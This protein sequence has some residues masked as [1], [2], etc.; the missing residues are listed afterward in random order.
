MFPFSINGSTYAVFLFV[1]VSCYCLGLPPHSNH[2]DRDCQPHKESPQR[3][4][5]INF[6][7]TSLIT[8]QQTLKHKQLR[9][10]EPAGEWARTTP[11]N[12]TVQSSRNFQTLQRITTLPFACFPPCLAT[13]NV[14]CSWWFH[15][16]CFPTHTT[17]HHKKSGYGYFYYSTIDGGSW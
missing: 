11:P 12:P 8:Q 14:L 9:M 13:W 4:H 2:L 5:V 6:K 7:N 16:S 1:C 3:L 17:P 15:E 10:H